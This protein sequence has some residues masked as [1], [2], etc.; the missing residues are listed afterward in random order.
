VLIAG[1]T[2][3][4]FV[5]GPGRRESGEPVEFHRRA[6]GAVTGVTIGPYT[7]DRFEPVPS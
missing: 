3:D 1:E 4:R 5:A 7:L 6:D 2:P